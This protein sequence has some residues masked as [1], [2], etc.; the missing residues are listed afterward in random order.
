MEAD[1]QTERCDEPHGLHR[2]VQWRILVERM[3][4]AIVPTAAI[5]GT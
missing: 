1:E 3:M 4:R 2:P 5:C